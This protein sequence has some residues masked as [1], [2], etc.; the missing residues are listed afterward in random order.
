[1]TTESRKAAPATILIRYLPTN[2]KVF[3][4]DDPVILP[5]KIP[6]GNY[7]IH[8]ERKGFQKISLSKSLASGQNFMLEPRWFPLAKNG[9]IGLLGAYI[10]PDDGDPTYGFWITAIFG[11]VFTSHLK[12]CGEFITYE[13]YSSDQYEEMAPPLY[14]DLNVN[15]SPFKAF[16]YKE[17]WITRAFSFS[18]ILKFYPIRGNISPFIGL[19]PTLIVARDNWELLYSGEPTD[20]AS[21]NKLSV[22]GNFCLGVDIF[23]NSVVRLSADLR[24]LKMTEDM[25]SIQFT[26]STMFMLW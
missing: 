6:P 7:T 13:S 1:M 9:G 5:Y 20:S 22:G 15:R 12:F 18:G 17:E 14:A 2:T 21:S 19:G 24:Y 16:A 10:L 26:A 11:N 8:L 4:N 3:V 25:G 23:L